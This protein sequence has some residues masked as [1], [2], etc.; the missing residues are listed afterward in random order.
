MG[1]LDLYMDRERFLDWG[2]G[3]MKIRHEVPVDDT[4]YRYRGHEV[5]ERKKV[6]LFYTF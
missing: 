4:E 2:G 3:E 6:G 5:V 1:T